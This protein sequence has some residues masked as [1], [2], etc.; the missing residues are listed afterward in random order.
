MTGAYMD[1]P[2]RFNTEAKPTWCPGCGDFGIQNAMKRALRSLDLQPHEVVISS[3][4]GCSGK[5]PHWIKAY[6][7]HGLH[8][9]A[10]P[11]A[12]GAKLANHKLVMIAAGGDG[13]GYSEGMGHFIHGCRRNVDMTYLVHNNGV[14]GLTT[15][16]V[17]PTGER[18]FVSSTTPH[19]ALELP[20]H[21]LALAISAGATFVARGFSGDLERLGELIAEAIRHPGFS[22]IDVLQ[23]CVSFNPSKSFKWYQERVYNLEDEGHD[24]TDRMKALEMVFRDDDR[25]PTGL[26]YRG[27]A[28]THEEGLP[29][30]SAEPLAAQDITSVDV[31]PLMEE[32]V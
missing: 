7:F 12:T 2:A 30:L 23:V 32:L 15:G 3:G 8:G 22:F 5:I 14:Y 27:S 20:F 19:G 6:G 26:F 25:L 4:I 24:P 11:V 10:L 18:G 21:P 16:Q 1:N 28:P 31:T 13:D 9:R 29:Q 17:S